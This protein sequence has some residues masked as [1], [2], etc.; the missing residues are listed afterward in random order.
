MRIKIKR[1]SLDNR[2]LTEDFPTK[3]KVK[4]KRMKNEGLR[5]KK[6]SNGQNLEKNQLDMY[7]VTL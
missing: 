6:K 1:M 4:E 2:K 5:I 3:R 7:A